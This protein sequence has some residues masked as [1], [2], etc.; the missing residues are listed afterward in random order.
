VIS[1]RIRERIGGVAELAAQNF[2]GLAQVD[3]T[4]TSA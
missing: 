1:A 2:A 3:R 4:V